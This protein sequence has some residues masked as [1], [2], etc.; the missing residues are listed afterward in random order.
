MVRALRESEKITKEDEGRDEICSTARS[1]AYNSA[2]CGRLYSYDLSGNK[3]AIVQ[4]Y[5]VKIKSNLEQ[6]YNKLKVS[7][8]V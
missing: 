1:K 8:N 4:E 7:G 6:I 2:I 3:T 5:Y